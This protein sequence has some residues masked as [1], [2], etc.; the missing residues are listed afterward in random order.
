MITTLN[1]MFI[2]IYSDL[3]KAEAKAAFEMKRR[4]RQ[5]R[6]NSA[7]RQQQ[8]QH[9]SLS[10]ELNHNVAT[11]VASVQQTIIIPG[12][13]EDATITDGSCTDNSLTGFP[14]TIT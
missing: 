12:E 7:A 1:R 8:Q 9:P 10:T 13:P 6:S 11:F 5:V 14:L 4:R 3:T 2:Y